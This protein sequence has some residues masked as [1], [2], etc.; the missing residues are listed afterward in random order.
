MMLT[1]VKN[2]WIRGFNVLTLL[3][4]DWNDKSVVLRKELFQERYDLH[5]FSSAFSVPTTRARFSVVVLKCEKQELHWVCLQKSCT[6][7]TRSG[8]ELTRGKLRFCSIWR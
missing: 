7:A 4:Y 5:I 3:N 8:K 1:I 2:A 6:T